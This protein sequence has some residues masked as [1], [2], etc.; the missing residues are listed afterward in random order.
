[1]KIGLFISLREHIILNASIYH[2][3]RRKGYRVYLYDVMEE[4]GWFEK[5][6]QYITLDYDRAVESINPEEEDFL[7][8]LFE[9]SELDIVIFQ[10]YSYYLLKLAKFAKAY[11]IPILHIGSGLRSYYPSEGEYI[12]QLVDHLTPYHATY[13]PKHTKNLIDEGFNPKYIKLIGYPGLDIIDKYLSSAD[14]KSSILDEMGLE[15]EDYI[16]FELENVDTIKYIDEIKK[17]SE[18]TGEYLIISLSKESKRYLVDNEEY[19]SIME[20]YDITFVELLD[21]LDHLKIMSNAKALFT[22][23]EWIAVEGLFLKKPTSIFLNS[24]SDLLVLDRDVVNVVTLSDGLSKELKKKYMY[25]SSDVEGMRVRYGGGGASDIL[26]DY[27]YSISDFSF[28]YP[29]VAIYIR[30]DNK[31][32]KMDYES[33]PEKFRSHLV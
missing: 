22:D 13:L 8:K 11:R 9:D 3:L 5:G 25:I 4:T 14:V 20:K 15:P 31:L 29:E 17:F 30:K 21:Y 28:E 10:G 16:Y 32:L 2:L 6:V 33:I 26:S 18:D 7:D 12:R 19:M 27:L 1:M 23:K 24:I